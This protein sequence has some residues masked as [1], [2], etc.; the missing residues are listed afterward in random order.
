VYRHR[1]G[2]F[3]LVEILVVIGVMAVLASLLIPS[4]GLARSMAYDVEC[5]NNLRQWGMALQ[6]YMKNHDG[7]I[8]RRGQ[9]ERVLTRLERDA[10]W[11]N[12]LPPYV[13]E[14]PYRELVEQERQPEA[15]H[16][17]IFICPSA[18]DPG[19]GYFFPYAMN[20]HLSPWFRPEPHNILEI[21]RP[22]RVVFM[23]DAPGPYS[24]TEPWAQ[25]FSV[26]AR[27]RGSANLVFLDGHV[28]SFSGEYLGCGGDRDPK[29]HDVQW[30]I[31]A[32]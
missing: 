12:C 20:R 28:K 19:V 11:F 10:D 1:L 22:T 9:G 23:S 25:P 18:T 27:H 17:S 21:D 32:E 8:P 3:T 6:M 24:S 16:E 29:R 14:P 30:A 31:E 7:Y 5:R 13:G 26:P 4:L 15:G 2:G